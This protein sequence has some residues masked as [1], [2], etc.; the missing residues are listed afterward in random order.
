MYTSEPRWHTNWFLSAILNANIDAMVNRYSA[1]LAL[2]VDLYYRKGTPHF[3]QLDHR[4]MESDIRMLM[5]TMSR[6]KPVV[7]YF[8]V[9]EY[10]QDRRYHAHV[11]FWL[12][13]H[14]TQRPYPFAEKAGKYWHDITHQH[15]Y[16]YRSIFQEHYKSNI[17]RPVYY[18]DPASIANIRQ[19]LSY[20][21]KE[22]QK[23]GLFIYGCNEV[24]PHP[25]RGRPRASGERRQATLI[26]PIH[27]GL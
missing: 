19:A 26:P 4:Q 25:E 1:L 20:L 6:L 11:V 15:G 2:R 14:K 22:E 17:N 27:Y 16:T 3:L 8:W 7:G 21:A 23:N 18:N 9:I 13:R 24:P 10:S 5:E 12:D